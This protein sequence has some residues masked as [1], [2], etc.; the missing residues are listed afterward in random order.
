[1]VRFKTMEE[2]P[3]TIGWYACILRDHALLKDVPC[4][5]FWTGD[6]WQVGE[7]LTGWYDEFFGS[8]SDGARKYATEKYYETGSV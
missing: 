2:K 6:D 3:L 4:A 1:M 7:N 8:N 5:R